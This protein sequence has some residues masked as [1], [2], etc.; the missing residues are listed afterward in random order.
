MGLLGKLFGSRELKDEA[1]DIQPDVVINPALGG[2]FHFV[3]EDVFTIMG[4]GTVVT[5]KVDSGELKVGDIVNI[6]GRMDSEVWGIEKF[7]KSLDYAQA[8]D[9]CGILLKGVAREDINKGD[10]LTK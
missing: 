2:K 5:G 9:N 8:G 6:S 4:R 10:T 3:V 1:Q 7:R